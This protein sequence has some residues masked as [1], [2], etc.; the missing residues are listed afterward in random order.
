MHGVPPASNPD[1]SEANALL[2]HS[3]GPQ[4]SY[5]CFPGR[6]N[7]VGQ[8]VPPCAAPGSCTFLGNWS[9][10]SGEHFH[11]SSLTSPP[12]QHDVKARIIVKAEEFMNHRHDTLKRILKIIDLW[13]RAKSWLSCPFLWW[14]EPVLVFPYTLTQDLPM[15][16]C[17]R[18]QCPYQEPLS[19]LSLLFCVKKEKVPCKGQYLEYDQHT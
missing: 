9:A 6:W 16:S 2:L 1:I 4:S 14:D 19:F 13:K 5:N 10:A 12:G 15:F 8:P 7:P 17:C 3:L 18:V 11:T